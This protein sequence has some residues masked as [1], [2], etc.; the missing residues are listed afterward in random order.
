VSTSLPRWA[1]AVSNSAGGGGDRPNRIR[2]GN[3]PTGE[4][5]ID[6]WFDIAAFTTPAQ[7]NFGDAGRGIPPDPLMW[8]P[9]CTAISDLRSSGA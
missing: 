3:L 2:E 4:R 5:T 8:I 7:F 9:V 6:R 1:A